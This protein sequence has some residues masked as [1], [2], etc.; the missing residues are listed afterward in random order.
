MT[1][2]RQESRA[3]PSWDEGRFYTIDGRRLPSVTTILSVIA[4]PGLGPWYAREERRAFETAMVEVA[5]RYRVI[6]GEQLLEAVIQAVDGVKAADRAKRE[7]AAIGTAAH[8][9]IEWETRTMLGEDVG[10]RPRLPEPAEWAVEAWKDWARSVDFRPLAI[11]RT[12]ACAGCGYAGTLDFLAEVRGTPTLGDYK[13]GRAI[14]PEAYLQNVAYRHAAG[15]HGLAAAQGVIVRL[16]K[17]LDDPGFE[18]GWV[19]DTVTLVEFRA[20]LRLWRWARRMAG[21]PTG[22]GP[23]AD[24]VGHD[25]PEGDEG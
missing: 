19:P 14:F 13:T 1:T 24:G 2:T 21:L 3:R 11:E 8:A 22:D 12:V 15:Q 25:A 10:P 18:V 9:G 16:P 6:T 7:A 4:K 5:A 17:R 23:R 20:A